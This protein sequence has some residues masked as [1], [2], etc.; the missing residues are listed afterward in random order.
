MYSSSD[1]AA[2]EVVFISDHPGETQAAAAAGM[3][4]VLMAREQDGTTAELT[5]RSFDDINLR[6]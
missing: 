2:R 3:S 6:F 5:A 1:Q 4:T